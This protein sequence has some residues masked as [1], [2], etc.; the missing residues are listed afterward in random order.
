MIKQLFRYVMV[1][2]C[3]PILSCK[4]SKETEDKLVVN[5]DTRPNILIAIMDDATYAHMGAYG[6]NW[7]NTPN[8][9]RVADQGLLFNRAYTPNA[10][11]SPSRSCILT[12]RN[13]WQ[14]EQAA[15]HWP[16]FP[17]KF[18]TYPEV[19][20]ENGYH[21]GY[22]DK[23]WAPGIALNADGSPR[24][25][26]GTAYNNKQT[27]PP[28][29]S[30][31]TNDYA[32]N[33]AEFIAQN[34]NKSP[35]CFWYGSR[36]P[37]RAYDSGIGIAKGNKNIAQIDSV[38][39]FWPD[40]KTVRSDLLDYAFEIEYFDTQ[41]GK[42]LKLLE[43]KN[44]L[45]NTIVLVTSDNGMPFPRIKGQEYEYSNHLPLAIMWKTGI[46][47]TGRVVDDFV[48]FIDFAP[49]F[50][51]YAKI[52]K[53]DSGMK[54]IEGRSLKPIFESSLSGIVDPSRN[55][56]VLIGKERHDIGRPNDWGYPIRGIIKGDFLFVHNFEPSRWP[57]GNPITG[58]LNCDGSP[59]K[60]ALLETRTHPE[61]HQFWK[62]SFGK[63]PEY[64]LY[65]IG[66][67]AECTK[68][69]AN[70]PQMKETLEGLKQLMTSELQRQHDPRIMGNGEVFDSYIY[71]DS[72]GVNF[73]ERYMKGESL[74][75]SWVNKT[76]F[77]ETD[78]LE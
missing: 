6:C 30:I 36:E 32:A 65:N 61:K 53:A 8:F 68:N 49:T 72:T 15:N 1:L 66:E 35:F 78:V 27:V 47:T 14:L 31:S 77:E 3:I 19:L 40:N 60:T 20:K 51:E 59:T 12:G 73:Y 75:Y 52:E 16:Y 26:V 58:Y 23:G 7:V 24:A 22:T 70:L 17:L 2:M 54:P 50:L 38:Y 18:K 71:A 9:D 41:L 43:E 42:M 34:S 11:C 64:E 13:S 39:S 44:Q 67:D 55:D 62:A 74:N 5:K 4:E 69:L 57:A 37:H 33:F 45:D 25:L 10:K 48:N 29:A 28:G 46:K 76:D 21:V 56:Y 63:R